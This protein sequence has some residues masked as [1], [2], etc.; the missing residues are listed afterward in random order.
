[1]AVVS[2]ETLE[3]PETL[4]PYGGKFQMF[5]FCPGENRWIC[6]E[7][8]GAAGTWYTAWSVFLW[9]LVFHRRIYVRNLCGKGFRLMQGCTKRTRFPQGEKN[10]SGSF[11]SRGDRPKNFYALLF[12]R[13]FP[14]DMSL[15]KAFGLAFH[16]CDDF[17]NFIVQSVVGLDLRFNGLNIAVYGGM[18]PIQHFSDLRER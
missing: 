10:F 8:S 2:V 13:L 11:S 3:S 4:V 5:Q 14:K 1:M 9:R 17:H 12:H 18:V 6:V 7:K 15:G 16:F